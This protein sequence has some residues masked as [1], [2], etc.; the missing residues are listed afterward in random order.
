MSIFANFVGDIA[1]KLQTFLLESELSQKYEGRTLMIQNILAHLSEQITEYE[2]H[3]ALPIMAKGFH[4]L[5]ISLG[6]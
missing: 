5:R 1:T 2:F 6:L 4:D 3:E